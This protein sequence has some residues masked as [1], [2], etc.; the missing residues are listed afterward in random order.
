MKSV[1]PSRVF[2]LAVCEYECEYEYEYSTDTNQ[3]DSYEYK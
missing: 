1:I 2:G 3:K